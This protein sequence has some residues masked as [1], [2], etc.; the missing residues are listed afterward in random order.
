MASLL[1]PHRPPVFCPGCSH[2]RSLHSLDRALQHL[3]LS[4]SEVAIVSDIGC[5]G[6]FDTFFATHALHGLHGRALT[7]AAGLKLARPDLTVVA[8]MGDGGMGIGG[9]HLLAACRRNLNVTLLVLNNFNFGMTGGQF[10]C[11]TPAEAAVASGLLNTLEKPMDICSVAAAAGAPY[12]RRCSVYHKDLAA[13]LAEAISFEGFAVVDV[14][15]LCPGRYLRWNRMSPRQMQTLMDELPPFTGAVAANQRPEYGGR[16][17]QQMRA[18]RRREPWPEYQS[19][20]APLLQA[21]REIVLL[22]SAGGRVISAGLLLARAA[23]SSG[24]HVTQKNDY[25]V[26]VMRGPSVSELILSPEPIDF[27]GVEQPDIVVALSPEGVARGRPFFARLDSEG[28]V[29]LAKGVDIPATAAEVQQLDFKSAGIRR[30]EAALAALSFLAR[31][32]KVISLEMLED[33][34]NRTFKGAKL[35]RAMEIVARAAKMPG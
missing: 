4:G 14:W 34:I 1:N 3:G 24:M 32:R 15:G 9:A 17:Q 8:T 20:F 6:L 11:T 19:D 18:K 2:D 12:V 28:Q 10:S 30:K 33:A 26:T 5:C 22:G 25:N 21:R 7:Y 35:A 27:T 16:Y 29:L 13:I 23:I 31:Q